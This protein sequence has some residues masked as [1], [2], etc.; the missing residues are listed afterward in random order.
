M[1][2]NKHEEKDLEGKYGRMNFPN[3]RAEYVDR[4]TAERTV[5]NKHNLEVNSMA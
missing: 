5:E 1:E 3:K 2:E 4:Q